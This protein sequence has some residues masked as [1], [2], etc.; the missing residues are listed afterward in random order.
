[1]IIKNQFPVTIILCKLLLR[2]RGETA[3]KFKNM[4]PLLYGQKHKLF[5]AQLIW[6]YSFGDR[7][8]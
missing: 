5:Y 2:T 3:V 7:F 4:F 6:T 8:S 1:M